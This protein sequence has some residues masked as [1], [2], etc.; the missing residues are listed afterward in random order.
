MKSLKGVM[1]L[2][3]VSGSAF[4]QSPWVKEKGSAYTQL[5]LNMITEYTS[6]YAS[7]GDHI[8]L[9]RSVTD[10]SIQFYGEFGIGNN[11]QLSGALPYKLLTTGALSTNYTGGPFSIQ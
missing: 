3:F 7:S 1:L 8:E 4:A 5:S 11:W 2:I 9:P 10:Q 6:I